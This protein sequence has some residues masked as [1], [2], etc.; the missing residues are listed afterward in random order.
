MVSRTVSVFVSLQSNSYG[1]TYCEVI[2]FAS[3]SYINDVLK[4]L[5]NNN[6]N[7]GN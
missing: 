1:L 3:I 2:C 5:Y 4:L 7:N 6:T